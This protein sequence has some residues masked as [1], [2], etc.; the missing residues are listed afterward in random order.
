MKKKLLPV[1]LVAGFLGL[2]ILSVYVLKSNHVAADNIQDSPGSVT[3]DNAGQI[4]EVD[5]VYDFKIPSEQEI[6]ETKNKI[7][8]SNEYKA[9][10]EA[11]GKEQAEKDL[12]KKLQEDI[13]YMVEM[14][15]IGNGKIVIGSPPTLPPNSPYSP[16]PLP[17]S[18]P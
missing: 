17:A 5:L 7:M 9:K 14:N 16:S 6:A 4:E 11:L 3:H 13:D 1:F 12:D 18:S 15:K 2:M 10:E 8:Q